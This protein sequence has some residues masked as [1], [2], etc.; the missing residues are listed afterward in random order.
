M[1]LPGIIGNAR[2]RDSLAPLDGAH[3]PHAVLI[4][5]PHGCGK[6]TLARTIACALVCTQQTVPCLVCAQCRKVLSGTHPD[7]TSI[8]EDGTE[9]TVDRIR[10]LRTDAYI[11]PNEAPKKIY[12]IHHAENMNLSAQNA[13]LKILEEPPAHVV[14]LLLCESRRALLD[15]IASRVVP[16]SMAPLSVQELTDELRR[17]FPAADE[18]SLSDAARVS[19][20]FLG[21]ACQALTGGEDEMHIA[22]RT[23]CRAL[24]TGSELSLLEASVAMEKIERSSF[25]VF[26]DEC[27]LFLRSAI[28]LKASVDPML[29]REDTDT[30]S[31]LAALCPT[32]MLLR[33]CDLFTVLKRRCAANGS[34][35]ALTAY[36]CAGSAALIRP[37]GASNQI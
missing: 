26:C 9:I 18:R 24:S 4:E 27:V 20:G 30:A 23:W 10:A 8:G 12:I 17:R 1:P 19:G 3:F 37:A 29:C 16:F 34:M 15:T 25:D 2:L 11:R 6:A 36:L 32:D 31:A 5:G 21:R 28:F 14:F 22:A 13:L 33:L 7:L 35:A